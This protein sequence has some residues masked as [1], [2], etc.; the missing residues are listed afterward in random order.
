MKCIG[1]CPVCQIK[2][3]TN[4]VIKLSY[5]R[6]AFYVFCYLLAH[7]LNHLVINFLYHNVEDISTTHTPFPKHDK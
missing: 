7:S 6:V 4:W 1:I 3:I 2:D 5:V